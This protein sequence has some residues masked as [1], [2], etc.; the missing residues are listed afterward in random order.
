MK[1]EMKI[2][3]PCLNY[4]LDF[5]MRTF[6]LA[7]YTEALMEEVVANNLKYVQAMLA[8]NVEHG[9]LFHRL[10]SDLVPFASHPVCK[11]DWASRF[12]PVWKSIGDTLKK[13]GF[14]VSM[15][16]SQFVVLNGKESVLENA[17]GELNYHVKVF[18]LMGLGSDAKIQIHVG[19]VYGDKEK[20][21]NLFIERYRDLPKKIRKHLVI[22]NDERSFSLQDCLRI[23]EA[24][25]I[26]IIFD[27]FHHEILN[28][29]ESWAEAVALAKET[30]NSPDGILMVDYSS[31][32]PGGRIGNHCTSIDVAHYRRFRHETRMHDFD[33]MLEIKDKEASALKALD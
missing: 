25:G 17:V 4:A 12:R 3:Y 8:Y 10:S 19:G 15:H 32:A 18:E 9:M 28:A 20:S 16:P 14:R 27:S 2:G 11:F 24:T 30:W 23:H 21:L 26:P 31:Q 1:A 7:S 22:E 6:R 29:G 33:I 13:N 5:K